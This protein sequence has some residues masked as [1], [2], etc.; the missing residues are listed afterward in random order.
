MMSVVRGRSEVTGTSQNDAIDPKRSN[1]NTKSSVSQPC[2]GSDQI[3]RI[4]ALAKPSEN[5]AEL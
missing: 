4:K 3:R 2:L 5:P 1:L